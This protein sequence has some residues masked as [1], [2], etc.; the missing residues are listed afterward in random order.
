MGLG[1]AKGC[2]K[3]AGSRDINISVIYGQGGRGIGQHYSISYLKLNL[4]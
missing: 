2:G 4:Q 3:R 1:S